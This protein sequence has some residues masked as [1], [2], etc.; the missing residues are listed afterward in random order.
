MI[1]G[2]LLV[3]GAI[4]NAWEKTREKLGHLSTKQFQTKMAKQWSREELEEFNKSL[5]LVSRRIH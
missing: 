1:I 4:S 2:G 3:L 5:S